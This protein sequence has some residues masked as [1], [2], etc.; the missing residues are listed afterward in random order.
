MP[1]RH[2]YQRGDVVLVP[3]PFSSGLGD[4]V[5]PAVVISTDIY[6]ADWNEL[7]LV[8][9]TSQP[10]QTLRPT[11]CELLDWQSAGLNRPSWARAGLAKVIY[12]HIQQRVGSLTARDFRAL[13]DCLRVALGF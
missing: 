6:H 1:A 3:L 9:V 10:P 12:R 4:K 11:D 5:R 8:E 7:L 13:E 2:P